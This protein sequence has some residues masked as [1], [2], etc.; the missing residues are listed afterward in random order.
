MFHREYGVGSTYADIAVPGQTV[1]GNHTLGAVEQ[2]TPLLNMTGWEKF[3][4]QAVTQEKTTV[5]LKGET[6]A[7]LGKLK[8]H[9]KLDKDVVAPS[10]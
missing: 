9:V 4:Q 2:F 10:K 5:S 8:T 6:D 7:F 3:V 1:K